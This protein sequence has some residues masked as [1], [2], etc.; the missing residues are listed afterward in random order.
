MV[1][2]KKISEELRTLGVPCSCKGFFYLKTAILMVQ[3]DVSYLDQLTKRLYVDVAKKYDTT[4]SRVERAIRHVI[5][6]I[7]VVGNLKELSTL[8]LCDPLKGKMTNGQFIGAL[9]ERLKYEE[10]EDFLCVTK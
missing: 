1:T 9:W 7:Y 8:G 2:E 3:E 6:R 4:S 5:E 10:E